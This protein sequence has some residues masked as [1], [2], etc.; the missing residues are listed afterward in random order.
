LNRQRRVQPAVA[1]TAVGLV[2]PQQER[3]AL[4]AGLRL[5]REVSGGWGRHQAPPRTRHRPIPPL[6]CLTVSSTTA[7]EDTEKALQA[8]AG[9]G[10]GAGSARRGKLRL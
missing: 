8:A 4:G 10:P 9:A 2:E 5:R 7:G 6:A 3:A 1:V